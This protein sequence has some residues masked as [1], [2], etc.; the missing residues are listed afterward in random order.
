M[1]RFLRV[2][3]LVGLAVTVVACGDDGGSNEDALS[4][5]PTFEECADA[6]AT[7]LEGFDTSGLDPSDG[8]DDAERALAEGRFDAMAEDRPFLAEDSPCSTVLSNATDEQFA[9]FAERLGP[10]LVAILGATAQQEFE[11]ISPTIG[12]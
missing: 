10:E 11:E 4:D 6:T 8:F 2:V 5:D 1:N 7:A 9:A 12:G 3:V